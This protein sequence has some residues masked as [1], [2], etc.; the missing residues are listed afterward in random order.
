MH[1]HTHKS[2]NF[3]VKHD[4]KNYRFPGDGFKY[5]LDMI[6]RVEAVSLE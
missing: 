4:I 2:Q 5:E 6:F 3:V 1:T